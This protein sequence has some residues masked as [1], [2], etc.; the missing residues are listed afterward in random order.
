MRLPSLKLADLLI[1]SDVV[2]IRVFG[3]VFQSNNTQYFKC[4]IFT[5]VRQPF[6]PNISI[7][8]FPLKHETES[9]TVKPRI[10]E[11]M[12]GGFRLILFR[13]I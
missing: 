3:K 5:V 13:Y 1:S 9:S 11:H 10:K 8:F 7:V 12:S 2:E 4:M 6:Q